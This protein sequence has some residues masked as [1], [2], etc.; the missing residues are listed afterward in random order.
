MISSPVET[1]ATRGRRQTSTDGAA[2]RRQHADL[3][4]GQNLPGMQHG[5]AAGHVAAGEGDE[6]TGS[7]RPADLD[8]GRVALVDRLGVLDHD[9]GVGAARHHA[10]GRDQ[11]RRARFDGEK[12]HFSGRQD[13]GPQGQAPR[14]A[15]AG[16]ERVVGAHREAVD[17]GAVEARNVDFGD[18]PARYDPRQRLRQRHGLAAERP[19]FEMAAEAALGLVAIEDFK[20]LLLTR[21]AAQGCGDVVHDLGSTRIGVRRRNQPSS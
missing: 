8:D 20:E 1:I 15:L 14:Y 21:Q 3:A 9:D 7:R 5:L 16:T 17:T 13:F 2:D 11:R 12:R 18:D 6:L 10:A 4:R 19:H